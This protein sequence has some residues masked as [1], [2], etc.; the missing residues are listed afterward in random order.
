MKNPDC[1]IGLLILEIL[2][3]GTGSSAIC[4]RQPLCSKAEKQERWEQSSEILFFLPFLKTDA[5]YLQFD[6]LPQKSATHK[7]LAP[8]ML[9]VKHRK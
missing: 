8:R 7:L 2:V 1:S 9:L 3:G 5:K 6:H 4:N